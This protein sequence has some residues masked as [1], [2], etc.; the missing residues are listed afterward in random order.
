MGAH[1]VCIL[2]FV[3]GR[4][5]D[6]LGLPVNCSLLRLDVL[7]FVYLFV[8]LMGLVMVFTFIL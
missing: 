7:L 8:V 1:G 4:L 6:V 3:S 2:I 5:L